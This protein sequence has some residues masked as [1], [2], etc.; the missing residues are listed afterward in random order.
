MREPATPEE[1]ARW[2]KE[3]GLTIALYHAITCAILNGKLVFDRDTGDIAS[4][5]SDEAN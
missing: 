2:A 5:A 4:V 1:G 3:H